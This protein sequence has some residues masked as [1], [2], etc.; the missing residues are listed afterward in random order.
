LYDDF[1]RRK[2]VEQQQLID[3]L[4]E[5]LAWELSAIAQ[6]IIYAAKVSGPQR[7][8]LARFLM[9][10]VPDETAHAKFL[11]EKVVA[12][13]GEPQTKA[14]PVPPAR[15]NKQMLEAILEAESDAAV[16][17]TERAE[18]AETF[19]DKGLQVQLED[20]VRE[21]SEHRDEVARILRDWSL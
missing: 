17:Y 7:P 4:N 15:T 18:Q 2:P 1:N 20:M 3:A 9:S 6:Y 16:R 12:M 13:G 11:A 21:E 19:G 5:D 14:K 10:E 8:E